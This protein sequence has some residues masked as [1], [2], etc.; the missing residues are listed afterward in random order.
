MVS[1]TRHA[2]LSYTAT[3]IASVLPVKINN[4]NYF[5]VDASVYPT[6]TTAGYN[7]KVMSFGKS[8]E[9]NQKLWSLVKPLYKIPILDGAKP[10]AV[11]L[12]EL[13]K[14]ME[15]NDHYPLIAWQRY[16]KGKSLYIGTD[17][18]WRL[19]YKNGDKY[20]SMF[21]GQTIRFL[22]LAR[23]LS[24]NRRTQLMVEQ[25]NYQTGEEVEIFANV[26]N[27][28]YE[29]V[30]SSKYTVQLERLEPEWSTKIQLKPVPDAPGLYQGFFTPTVPGDYQISSSDDIVARDKTIDSQA[31]NITEFNVKPRSMKESE[32]I[33]Q[34]KLLKKMAELS[35]GKYFS[36]R[37]LPSLSKSLTK[38]KQTVTVYNEKEI[39]NL[40]IIFIILVALMGGEWLLRRK[41]DLV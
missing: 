19:R 27:E 2:P 9:R 32:S 37:D 39:W 11:V 33:L 17:Q 6:V 36:I 25:E 21:W 41:Y 15:Y 38:E 16:G 3:P 30:T 13:S 5:N 12:T 24:G 34:E 26:L 22:T 1:G 10:G 8:R 28:S 20:H 18:L 31:A 14:A 23:L 29:P 40:P 35:G 7:T 4:R